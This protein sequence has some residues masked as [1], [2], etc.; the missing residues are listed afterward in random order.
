[1][2]IPFEFLL[3]K[4][5]VEVIV[6][7]DKIIFETSEH[8]YVLCHDQDCCEKVYV[9]SII[10]DVNDLIGSPITLAE[11]ASNNWNASED[12]RVLHAL[13]PTESL[14]PYDE[15]WT[16]TFYKLATVKGYVD[17]RW[18]GSSNGYYSETV[19]FYR[20]NI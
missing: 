15:S 11:E 2:L 16:W 20:Y 5:L 12:S 3:G 17:I 18:Y 19:S 6:E 4:T 13:M 14:S 7:E 10:G 1:M 9:E 8:R